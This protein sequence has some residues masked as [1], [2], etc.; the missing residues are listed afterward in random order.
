MKSRRIEVT[1][2]RPAANSNILPQYVLQRARWLAHPEADT[3]HDQFDEFEL[4]FE[5]PAGA[6]LV[7]HVSADQRFELECDGVYVGMGPDR[8]DLRNWSFHSY[9]LTLPAGA[10]RFRARVQFIVTHR[11]HA[12]VSLR[13]AFILAAEG[14]PVNLDTGTAAWTVRRRAGVTCQ[15]PPF[16]SKWYLVAGPHFT[17]EG[18]SYF[19]PAAPVEPALVP[20]TNLQGGRVGF[21]RDGWRLHPSR[22]PEQMRT[23]P[24]RPGRIRMAAEGTPETMTESPPEA[25]ADWA[26][27]LSGAGPLR[28]KAG[29]TRTVLWDL[30][31][32][33]CAYPRLVVSGGRGSSIRWEWAEAC[34]EDAERRRKDDRNAIEGKYFEGYGDTYRPGGGAG[35]S[36]TSFWWRA[37]RYVRLTVEA[38]AEE[39]TI[40]RLGIEETRLPWEPEGSFASDDAEL[41]A[42][43]PMAVRGLQMCAHETYMDCPYYE[44]MMYVGDTRLQ[45]LTAAVLSS[46]RR[47]HQR[48]LEILDWSRHVSDFVLMRHPSDPRQLS[49]TFSMVWILMIRDLAFWQRDPAFIAGRMPGLRAQIEQFRALA[50]ADGLFTGLPAWSFIDWVNSPGWDFAYPPAGESGTSGIV[51]LLF[52]LALQSAIEVEEAYGEPPFAENYRAW[53]DRLAASI[54]R[55]F[56]N[57]ERGL[58]ADDPEHRYFSEHAQC[59]AILSGRF[60]ADTVGRCFDGLLKNE[61]LARTSVYF[62]FYLF[63]AL[64]RQGRGDLIVEKLGFWKELVRKG[65]KA[66]VEQPEPSR[67][68]CH[69]WGSHPLYHMNA[70][71]CGIRPAS[72]G[73]GTVRI[74]PQPGGL[75]HLKCRTVHPDGFIDFEMRRRGDQWTIRVRMPPGLAGV[76]EFQG[77]TH[78][79]AGGLDLTVPVKR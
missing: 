24:I 17:V 78:P 40:D 46:E 12:Q 73:F 53:A 42:I 60:D 75:N 58:F 45:L 72:A 51:N 67:S 14:S 8:S 26:R 30:E 7:A 55:M 59:L 28:V 34:Y 10:H 44:Q 13:P 11:A 27:L 37:G 32:Y 52:L 16:A 9:E 3:A 62:S 70:S 41:N 23:A 35:E 50:D 64:H 77:E 65:F 22:L 5:L 15:A 48:A 4:A 25:L 63:E 19:A 39:L 18:A 2:V 56:W 6:T 57:A 71:L 76:F 20:E 47:L 61:T 38:G 29:V 36:Y 21:V 66:P 79:L 69:A 49:T 31:D 1:P 54:H 74:T 33:Y 68:D 43:I